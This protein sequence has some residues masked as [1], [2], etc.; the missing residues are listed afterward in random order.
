[1]RFF[2]CR[3]ALLCLTATLC[4]QEKPAAPVPVAPAPAAAKGDAAKKDA[5]PAAVSE[6]DLHGAFIQVRTGGILEFQPGGKLLGWPAGGSWKFSAPNHLDIFSQKDGK[7]ERLPVNVAAA[8]GGLI[9]TRDVGGGAE[10]TILLDRLK[11]AK[12]D[13]AAW[14]GP[15]MMHF[16]LAGEKTATKRQLKMDDEGYLRNK[17]GGYYLRI[18]EDKQGRRLAHASNLEDKTTSVQVLEVANL[19][20]V[21]DSLEKPTLLSI[22]QLHVTE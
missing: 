8:G 9:L 11:P 7:E 10:E 4:G 6:K 19:L 12:I 1:M 5:A 15:C 3:L 2:P 21:F 22:I 20:V 18:L 16:L 13:P 17:E 14:Q